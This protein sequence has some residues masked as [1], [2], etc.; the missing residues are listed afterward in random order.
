MVL[1][2]TAAR[3]EVKAEVTRAVIAGEVRN[4]NDAA[5]KLR[6]AHAAADADPKA[7]RLRELR[8]AGKTLAEAIEIIDSEGS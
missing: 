3:A 1:A 2:R 6:A 8:A 7:A 4:A 5:A